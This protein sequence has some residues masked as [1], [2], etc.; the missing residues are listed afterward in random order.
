M[1]IARR[2]DIKAALRLRSDMVQEQQSSPQ[3]WRLGRR[4]SCLG[5][6]LSYTGQARQSSELLHRTVTTLPYRP[7][8]VGE[9]HWPLAFI[10]CT[11]RI[12]T[13]TSCSMS[14][15]K[16]PDHGHRP[17]CAWAKAAS[18][19]NSCDGGRWGPFF[20]GASSQADP[21]TSLW[22]QKLGSLG[23]GELLLE[24]A[25]HRRSALLGGFRPHSGRF[26]VAFD[27]VES[28]RP[29]IRLAP[30]SSPRCFWPASRDTYLTLSLNPPHGQ[31]D[32]GG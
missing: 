18:P 4:R 12:T 17:S 24:A 8:W 29:R 15:R 31:W 11:L 27:H 7:A 5:N 10:S 32:I 2:Q 30:V 21:E 14:T 19:R 26:P 16:V 6:L 1:N 28:Q 20:G 3:Q 13:R 23:S 22:P 9:R 25:V